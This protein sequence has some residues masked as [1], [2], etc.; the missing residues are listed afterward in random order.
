MRSHGSH[1][2]CP[3]AGVKLQFSE[4][5]DTASAH[6]AWEALVED[7][8]TYNSAPLSDWDAQAKLKRLQRE[9]D[10]LK[11][12]LAQMEAERAALLKAQADAEAA[13]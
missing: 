11:A 3:S 7:I 13:W 6:R 12:K 5:Y 1:L 8:C 4:V 10:A 2:Q 9:L